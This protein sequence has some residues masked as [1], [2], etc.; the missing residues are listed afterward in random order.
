[1][2]LNKIK[3]LSFLFIF[4]IFLSSCSLFT[5][6]IYEVYK[7]MESGEIIVDSL[8]F[9]SGFYKIF[10]NSDYV[11]DIIFFSSKT[12]VEFFKDS[13]KLYSEFIEYPLSYISQSYFEKRFYIFEDKKLYF[14]LDNSN[15]VTKTA[16]KPLVYFTITKE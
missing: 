5:D 14:V 11:L 13:S 9:T 12:G 3:F 6:K 16:G 4:L 7:T 2:L 10:L 15:L 1:M 8:E